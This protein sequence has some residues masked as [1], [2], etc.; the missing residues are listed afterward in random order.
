MD[1]RD[2]IKFKAFMESR[3]SWTDQARRECCQTLSTA[4]AFRQLAAAMP[5]TDFEKL[6]ERFGFHDYST[7]RHRM[8]DWKEAIVK[9]RRMQRLIRKVEEVPNV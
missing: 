8:Y 1:T 7:K 3:F 4:I 5:N 2:L 6:A 9:E